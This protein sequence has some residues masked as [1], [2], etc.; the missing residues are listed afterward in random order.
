MVI[1]RPVTIPGAP[2]GST[3]DVWINRQNTDV[4][5][6]VQWNIVSFVANPAL[7]SFHAD[8]RAFIDRAMTYNQGDRPDVVAKLDGASAA[9]VKAACPTIPGPA[10]MVNGVAIPRACVM[11]SWW[12]TSVQAGFEIW[13][14]PSN[15]GGLSSTSF[16]VTPLTIDGDPA[17]A[18]QNTGITGNTLFINGDGTTKPILHWNDH[19]RLSYS[20]CAT[21][22]V[23]DG[24]TATA[25]ATIGFGNTGSESVTLSQVDGTGIWDGPINPTQPGHDASSISFA[26]PCGDSVTN[27]P[28]FIDP[29]G[30]VT[31]Q[32]GM[33]INGATVT[34]GLCTNGA[35]STPPCPAV[36]P[37]SPLITPNVSSQMTPS[38]SAAGSGPGTFRWDVSGNNFWTVTASA[39]GCNTVTIGPLQVPPPRVDLLLKLT[40]AKNAPGIIEVG[41]NPRPVTGGGTNL[42][43]TVVVRPPGITPFNYCADVF[44]TNNTSAP[45]EWNTSF[46]VPGNY[47]IN[48]QWNMVF[49][50]GGNPNVATNVHAD[51]A[52]PWNK[53]LQPG[54]TTQSVGFCAVPN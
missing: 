44:V 50:Q 46:T 52:N 17:F 21:G 43:T 8:T 34:L 30:K 7:P 5:G 53:I 12:L 48:Q 31:N 54:Q 22:T 38:A 27:A 25:T 2:A 35:A 19:A 24:G 40:C 16:S 47:R 42:P 14:L 6:G 49:T 18:A 37:G 13:Q 41:G 4:T 32:D 20:G 45:V 11:P 39:P 23:G 15:G 3:W 9:S 51:P 29:S 28:I 10:G 1:A 26:L 33:P 36:N